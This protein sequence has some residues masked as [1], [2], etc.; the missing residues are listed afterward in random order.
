MTD[1]TF[2][3]LQYAGPASWHHL[4]APTRTFPLTDGTAQA[5][6]QSMDAAYDHLNDI[7]AIYALT[8]LAATANILSNAIANTIFTT[9]ALD[10]FKE[11]RTAAHI[12]HVTNRDTPTFTPTFRTYRHFKQAIETRDPQVIIR[13]LIDV[14]RIAYTITES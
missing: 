6:A 5:A 13:L 7:S 14:I 10:I 4:I 1:E 8:D 2:T 12:L 3:A 11:A 9:T